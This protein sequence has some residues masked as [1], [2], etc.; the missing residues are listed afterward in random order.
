MGEDGLPKVPE[1]PIELERD[2]FE[3]T[4]TLYPGSAYQLTTVSKRVQIWMEILI[5]QTVVLGFPK[6]QTNLFLQTVDSRPAS[7]FASH[8]KNLYL[9]FVSYPQA[10]KVLSVCTGVTNLACWAASS[11]LELL[12]LP[13]QPLERLSVNVATLMQLCE[14]RKPDFSHPAFRALTHLDITEPPTSS[15]DIDW[16][17]LY[18]LPKLTHI[19]IGNLTESHHLFL[20]KE[21]LANCESLLYLVVISDHGEFTKR[22]SEEIDDRRLKILPYFHHPKEY[23]TYWEDV[24]R[25][26]PDF[27]GY[28]GDN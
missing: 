3:L 10:Q 22:V 11:S 13:R 2:I 21:L 17:A 19:S 23:R 14:T 9:T 28:L 4:A 24:Q 15:V 7:F 12:P 18:K 25:G 6:L 8:V 1:L 27:W 20:L 26:L 16:S 5:Y